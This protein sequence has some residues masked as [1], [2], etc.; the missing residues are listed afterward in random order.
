MKYNITVIG[1]GALGSHVIQLL[2]NVDDGNGTS[3]VAVDFDRVEQKNTMSQF[4]PKGTVGRHKTVALQQTMN[5]LWGRSIDA[6]SAKVTADNVKEILQ[7]ANLVIDCLDNG[8]SRRVI[9]AHV[10]E[11]AYPCLHGAL[12]ANGSFGR[13]IW[14]EDFVIDD[15]TGQGGGTCEDGAHLPFI[16]LVSSY[17]AWAAQEFHLHGKK[18]GFSVSMAGAIRI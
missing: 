14:D 11:K 7:G 12:A 18:M 13:V 15:E 6:K 1:V 2:R 4:H 8:A 16:A 9:Q 5:F 3:L 10:R 17:I